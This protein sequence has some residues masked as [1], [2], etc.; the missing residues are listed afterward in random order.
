MRLLERQER[1]DREKE[2]K[3]MERLRRQGEEAGEKKSRKGRGRQ[4]ITEEEVKRQE[5]YKEQE[6]HFLKESNTNK[7]LDFFM[8]GHHKVNARA[9]QRVVLLH[10]L[11]S[12]RRKRTRTS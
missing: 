2:K 10:F 12:S 11:C 1:A 5:K 4:Q 8:Q 7:A 3:E 6:Q 9:L